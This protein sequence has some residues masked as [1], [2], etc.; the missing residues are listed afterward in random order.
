MIRRKETHTIIRY[1]TSYRRTH[2]GGKKEFCF[3]VSF[4]PVFISEWITTHTHLPF[5]PHL[6]ETEWNLVWESMEYHHVSLE[7]RI[8]SENPFCT[9][10]T[11]REEC[12]NH[13]VLYEPRE[14]RTL[15]V[16]TSTYGNSLRRNPDWVLLIWCPLAQEHGHHQSKPRRL[17][18]CIPISFSWLGTSVLWGLLYGLKIIDRVSLVYVPL[19]IFISLSRHIDIYNKH[20]LRPLHSVG[21]TLYWWDVCPGSITGYIRR[22]SSI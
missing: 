11:S 4:I 10:V 22:Q 12:T 2:S 21:R 18:F 8:P 1:N 20:G 17:F 16:C 9:Y 13:G 6:G 3:G 15:V 14:P 5:R 19:R 7:Q